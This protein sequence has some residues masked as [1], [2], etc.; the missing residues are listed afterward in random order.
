MCPL[1]RSRV[2]SCFSR[3]LLALVIL[4]AGG[5]ALSQSPPSQL[6]RQFEGKRVELKIDMPAN[7]AGVD[8]YPDKEQPLKFSDYANRLKRY[9][10]AIHRGDSALVTKVQQ[11]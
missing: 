7:K 4:V 11:G 3:C 6:S 1:V 5:T 8:I 10:T 9:G 2:A